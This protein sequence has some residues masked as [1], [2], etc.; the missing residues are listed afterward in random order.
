MVTIPTVRICF[1]FARRAIV[2]A[3][4]VPVPPPIPAA[5]KIILAPSTASL[6]SVR[7]SS[8]APS[9]TSGRAPAPIPRVSF[10][11]SS[12]FLCDLLR[13]KALTSV[14][15]IIV[16]TLSRSSSAICVTTF[17]PAPPTPIIF[18]FGINAS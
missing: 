4:P 2:G 11:P 1:S 16:S 13:F 10:L 18:M 8:A 6:N 5:M 17:P 15:Q 9:P 12:I 7:L 3:A 14:L